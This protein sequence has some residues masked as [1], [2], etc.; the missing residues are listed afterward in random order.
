MWVIHSLDASSDLQPGDLRRRLIEHARAP[1]L[2]TRLP[3][4][5]ERRAQ[6]TLEREVM[7]RLVQAGY[8]VIPCWKVG[9]RSIDLVVEGDG[10]RLAIEC[11]GD[12]ELSLEELRE[13]MD[14]QT[15]LER[16]GWTFARVRGSL[17]FR[18]PD[19][20][21]KP[22][23][24]KLQSLDVPTKGPDTG[25][26]QG[27]LKS[28]E[29]TARIMRRAAE[30]RDGWSVPRKKRPESFTSPHSNGG[31]SESKGRL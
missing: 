2:L 16:L 24:E 23:L 14:R 29:L 28:D 30:L 18:E 15:M 7:K 9:S 20:A 27:R 11:D 21:M 3:E 25:A 6:S 13:D 31:A 17:F 4:D 12:R 22:I 26:V 5:E 8:N 1:E 19:R 10:M